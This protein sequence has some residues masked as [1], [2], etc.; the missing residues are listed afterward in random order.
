MQPHAV[1]VPV[2][3]SVPVECTFWTEDDGWKGAC[4]TLS[5]SV[6]GGNFEEAKNNMQSALQEYIAAVLRERTR[7]AA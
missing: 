3:T 7:G 2:I 6:R 1:T 5:L 4:R